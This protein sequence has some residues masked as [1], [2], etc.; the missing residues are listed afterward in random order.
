M[1]TRNNTIK[2]KDLVGLAMKLSPQRDN[3]QSRFDIGKYTITDF[4]KDH[5]IASSAAKA[6]LEGIGVKLPAR[7][8]GGASQ[9]KPSRTSADALAKRVQVLEN[10]VA[11]LC[12]ELGSP[13]PE[14][15]PDEHS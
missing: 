7:N 14:Y 11:R 4:A 2:H 13:A 5:Q 9:P 3:I 15:P 8:S 12:K 6:L 1:A 10:V